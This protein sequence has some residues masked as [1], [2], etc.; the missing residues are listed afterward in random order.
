YR[1][2]TVTTYT[3]TH[4]QQDKQLGIDAILRGLADGRAQAKRDFGVEMRWVFDIPRNLGFLAD[5]RYDPTCATICL[6]HAILGQEVGV[7]G[8]GLG[9]N[10]QG[11]PPEPYAHAFR[12]A[13]EAGLLSVPHASEMAGP[14][15]IWGCLRDLQADRIGHGVRAIEDPTLLAYL[16][17]RQ[18]PLEVNPVSNICL[19]VY[20]SL[21]DHPFQKLDQL[22]LHLTINSDDPPLFNTDLLNEYRQLA[23]TFGYGRAD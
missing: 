6:E 12:Q 20:P 11:T 7:I 8:F 13:K 22:G 10:E 15:S 3:H 23:H 16:K 9:G 21:A 5:G 17:E 19:H 1:E 18:I 2:L 4:H 14:A